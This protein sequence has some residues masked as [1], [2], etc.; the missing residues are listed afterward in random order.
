MD[1]KKSFEILNLKSDASLADLKQTYRDLVNVWHPDR[2]QHN[3]RLKDKAE[4]QLLEINLAYQTALSFI[5]STEPPELK[6]PADTSQKHSERPDSGQS[7][8]YTGKMPFFKSI[9]MV[10]ILARSV[11]IVFFALILAYMEIPQLFQ[12]LLGGWMTFIFAGFLLWAFIEANL[13]SLFGTTPGKWLFSIQ[14]TNPGGKKPDLLDTFKRSIH[15]WWRGLGAGCVIV[16]PFTLIDCVV[17][18]IRNHSIHWDRNRRILLSHH[19]R[20]NMRVILAM[21]ILTLGPLILSW[22]WH[23]KWQPK[24]VDSDRKIQGSLQTASFQ[25]KQASSMGETNPK[26]DLDNPIS[27]GNRPNSDPTPQQNSAIP[28]N[29]YGDYIK[30]YFESCSELEICRPDHD[31]ARIRETLLSTYGL[32]SGHCDNL[33]A[34]PEGLRFVGVSGTVHRLRIIFQAIDRVFGLMYEG[35]ALDRHHPADIEAAQKQVDDLILSLMKNN[36]QS[37]GDRILAFIQDYQLLS[38]NLYQQRPD[39]IA[40][41]ILTKKS[42]QKAESIR[43]TKERQE[44]EYRRKQI[45]SGAIPIADLKDAK[46]FYQAEDGMPL[47]ISPPLPPLTANLQKTFYLVGGDIDGLDQ[48]NPSMYRAIVRNQATILYFKFQL[49]EKIENRQIRIGQRVW[50]IGRLTDTDRYVTK[51]R[52]VRYMPVFTA[53]FIE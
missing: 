37:E 52:D 49:E 53:C 15:V 26:N 28:A 38:K 36:Y 23:E 20:K 46:W 5:S 10:R 11:D 21:T 14:L 17:S 19:S 2:F 30:R 13:L 35:R 6:I 3:P 33:D 4:K 18:I 41:L 48:K 31:E 29:L 8:K 45:Q 39:V 40:K 51:A 34:L 1:I 22:M 25:K 7:T 43:Q 42:R 44:L 50:I 47:L 9:W 12:S 24:P 16:M 27:S 32:C